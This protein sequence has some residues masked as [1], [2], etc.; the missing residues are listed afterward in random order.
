MKELIEEMANRNIGSLCIFLKNVKNIE[1]M[2]YINSNIPNISDKSISEKVYYF[3]NKIDNKLLCECGEHL[4]FI[5]FKNGY[6]TSCGKKEC[7]V[8]KRK[9]TCIEKYGVDNPKK[10][11]EVLE[12]EKKSIL[13]KW[14]GKHYMKDTNVINKFNSTMMERHG[15]EWSMQSK[16]ILSKSLETWK[17]NPDKEEIIKNRTNLFINKTTEEKNE[18]DLK[19]KRTLKNNWE[20]VENFYK[21]LSEKVKEKSIMNYGLNH[22]FSHP[23]IINKKIESYKNNITNKIIQNLPSSIK[24][25]N[26]KLNK[27]GSDSVIILECS[28]CNNIFDINRQ[29]LKFNQSRT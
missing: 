29:M 23:D 4:S 7:Y 1:Y 18:I 21:H 27:N 25:I 11:K 22:H 13:E 16:K 2:N 17:N 28:I 26:R 8:K 19:K 24:Y 6:R 9:E 15:V 10:S 5:G 20:S 12:K 14:N 3:I